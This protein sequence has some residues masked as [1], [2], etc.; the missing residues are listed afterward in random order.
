MPKPYL[1][2]DQYQKVLQRAL[3][4]HG[5]GL[6][7]AVLLIESRLPTYG[8]MLLAECSSR[9]IDLTMADV[10]EYLWDVNNSDR[11]ADGEKIDVEKTLFGALSIEAMLKWASL[12]NRGRPSATAQA[13][14]S[15]LEASGEL[16]AFEPKPET[17]DLSAPE[18][19]YR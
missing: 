6:P 9:G 18:S 15:L 1:N 2:E 12:K 17:V 5:V 7:I 10:E 19:W 4:S 14:R 3:N 16:E 13:I 8:S 11:W